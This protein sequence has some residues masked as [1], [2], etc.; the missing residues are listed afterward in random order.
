V[1]YIRYWVKAM[2]F[3]DHLLPLPH[4]DNLLTNEVLRSVAPVIIKTAAEMKQQQKASPS[5]ISLKALL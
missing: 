3:L 1:E 4:S 5:H 2:G